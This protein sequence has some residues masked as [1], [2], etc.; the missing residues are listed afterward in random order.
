M[1]FQDLTLITKVKAALAQAEDVSALDIDVDV[2]NGI[3]SLEGDV[4]KKAH[5]RAIEIVK[6]IQDVKS[7]EDCL[8]ITSFE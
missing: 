6:G 1:T 8:N 2:K 5:D 4:S 7:V 3:V